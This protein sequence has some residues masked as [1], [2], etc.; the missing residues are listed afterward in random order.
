MLETT[1][2]LHDDKS[3]WRTRHVPRWFGGLP[4]WIKAPL[5]Y[6]WPEERTITE[7]ELIYGWNESNGVHVPGLMTWSNC[8]A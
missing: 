4:G 2:A 8:P 5:A 1:I 6:A 7:D 3:H